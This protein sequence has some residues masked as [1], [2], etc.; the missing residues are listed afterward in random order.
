M[1]AL[2]HPLL[3]SGYRLIQSK[4]RCPSRQISYLEIRGNWRHGKVGNG[5]GDG[6]WSH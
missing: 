3:S 6:F 1:R 5:I 4:E 2:V